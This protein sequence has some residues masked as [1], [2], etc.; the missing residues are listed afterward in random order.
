M[1][2]INEYNERE[3]NRVERAFLIAVN[4]SVIAILFVSTAILTTVVVLTDDT[5]SSQNT[6]PVAVYNA[7]NNTIK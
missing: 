1:A 2:T 3:L 6:V 5:E 4:V 7:G